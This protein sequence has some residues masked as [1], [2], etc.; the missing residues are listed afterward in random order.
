MHETKIDFNED[1]LY[2][3]VFGS[4]LSD[5]QKLHYYCKIKNMIEIVC[6]E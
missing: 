1:I 2:L 6:Y 3:S 5:I 4:D